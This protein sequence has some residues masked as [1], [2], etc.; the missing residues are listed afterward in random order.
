MNP[1]KVQLLWSVSYSSTEQQSDTGAA[2]TAVVPS[3]V[4]LESH[5]IP[6]NR[7]NRL[8]QSLPSACQNLR[9]QIRPLFVLKEGCLSPGFIA[10]DF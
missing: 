7:P 9:T 1:Q 3:S 6:V 4:V 10:V 8:R 5:M 2:G